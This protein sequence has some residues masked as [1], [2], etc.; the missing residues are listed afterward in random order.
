MIYI[1]FKTGLVIENYWRLKRQGKIYF[2]TRKLRTEQGWVKQT[3][4]YIKINQIG[5]MV[6]LERKLINADF[7]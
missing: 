4:S 2:F 6:L 1:D 5:K 7:E 3:T